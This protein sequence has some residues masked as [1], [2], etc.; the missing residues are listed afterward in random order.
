MQLSL[1]SIFDILDYNT[2]CF[3]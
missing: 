2:L 1:L 3:L